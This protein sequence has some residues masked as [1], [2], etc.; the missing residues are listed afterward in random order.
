MPWSFSFRSS[1]DLVVQDMFRF[2]TGKVKVRHPIPVI[3]RRSAVSYLTAYYVAGEAFTNA[4]KHAKACGADT[5]SNGPTARKSATS[6]PGQQLPHGSH[7]R[8]IKA[9]QGPGR[10]RA[11]DLL[12]QPP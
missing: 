11:C 2:T 12:L 5:S 1:R 8:Q 6:H 10:S 4:T 7:R 3:Q 9:T